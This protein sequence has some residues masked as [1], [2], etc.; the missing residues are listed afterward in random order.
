MFGISP[1]ANAN[2]I[3]SANGL[4]NQH[5]DTRFSW[6]EMRLF[7]TSAIQ[8]L[9][10]SC[11]WD[12]LVSFLG[13]VAPMWWEEWAVHPSML[14]NVGFHLALMVICLELILIWNSLV[15]VGCGWVACVFLFLKGDIV[16]SSFHYLNRKYTDSQSMPWYT[17]LN[18]FCTLWKLLGHFSC[19]M[20]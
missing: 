7:L 15:N 13:I 10:R 18:C 19:T 12:T 16:R 3:C 6:R 9:F 20:L 8:T 17:I 2:D 4:A 5:F 11:L 14:L 1:L